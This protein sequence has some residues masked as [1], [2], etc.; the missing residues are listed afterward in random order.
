MKRSIPAT[1]IIITILF[2]LGVIVVGKGGCKKVH[3]EVKHLQS[4]F[5]G[6]NR[7]VTLYAHDGSVITNWTG[8]INIELDSGIP[9]FIIK[10]KVIQING[11][12]TIV[13]N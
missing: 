3:Q 4:G 13:E 12:Y 2:L 7:T 10:N 5:I 8:N 6:I 11:T 1:I 9:R